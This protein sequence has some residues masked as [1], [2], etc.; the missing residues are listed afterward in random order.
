MSFRS[1]VV[2]IAICVDQRLFSSDN[3]NYTTVD[4]DVP[5]LDGILTHADSLACEWL[6]DR[7]ATNDVDWNIVALVGWDR[8][9]EQ[10]PVNF[11]ASDQSTAGSQ[12]AAPANFT[13]GNWRRHCRLQL[14]YKLHAGVTVPKEGRL[15]LVLHVTTKGT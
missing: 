9:N 13:S 15:N 2:S 8:D 14:I 10:P 7:V 4:L 11:F 5:E 1:R 6:L 3:A 12:L